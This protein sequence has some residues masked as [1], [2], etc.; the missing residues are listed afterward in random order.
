MHLNC[1]YPFGQIIELKHYVFLAVLL[2]VLVCFFYLRKVKRSR[3]GDV[4][5]TLVVAGSMVNIYE[6]VRIGCVRDYINFAGLFYNNIQ[7][8]VIVIG[9]GLL[10]L[11]IWKQTK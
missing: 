5:L 9:I 4:G 2:L 10:S 8:I 7:D 6:W 3:L 1:N 11:S